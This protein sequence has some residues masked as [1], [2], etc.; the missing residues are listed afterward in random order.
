MKKAFVILSASVLA[1]AFLPSLLQAQYPYWRYDRLIE[2]NAGQEASSPRVAV[3]GT[4]AVAVW[5]QRYDG[6]Y[7]VYSNYS[8]NGGATWHTAKIIEDNVGC[9]ASDA[10]VVLSGSKAVAVWTQTI[11]SYYQVHANYSTDGGATWHADRLIDYPAGSQS[12]GVQAA[13][14][15]TRVAVVWFHEYLGALHVYFNASLDAG[16]TWRNYPLQIETTTVYESKYPHV[17]LS[18]ANIAVVWTRTDGSKDRVFYNASADGGVTW[19]SY[20]ILDDNAGYN[21]YAPKVAVSGTNAVA[22]WEQMSSTGNWRIYSS[23]STD[24]GATWQPDKLVADLGTANQNNPQVAISRTRV[25]AIWRQANL[26]GATLIY[27]CVSSDGGMNWSTA[28]PIESSNGYSADKPQLALAGNGVAAVWRKS[29]GHQSRVFANYSPDKGATW[30]SER[31]IDGLAGTDGVEP[32]VA[33]SS[34][35]VVAAWRVFDGLNSRV[36]A[37]S[38][39]Y[40]L[41]QKDKLKPPLL[42]SPPSGATGLTTTV[43]FEWQ[44]TNGLPQERKLKIRLKPAGGLYKFFT[45]PADY[46]SYVIGG[47]LPGK[48][49]SWN[50]QAVGNGAN[51]QNSTW[52]NG[53]RDWVFT[54][55]R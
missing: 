44:D 30:R 2:G 5:C 41:T 26:G 52:A 19:R 11:G 20:N 46:T 51:I 42:T 25:V 18:G 28:Q 53:G 34:S 3:S 33:L 6:T 15:G 47:L 8:T 37:N 43:A 40:T 27:S 48:I 31:M 17:A 29:D 24:G 36:A 16:K 1:M 9:V 35:A 45:V 38:A 14:S 7:R 22:V 55:A 21:V 54:T 50:I 13:I 32:D 49:Y 4:N 23:S 39:T 12:M 10:Q